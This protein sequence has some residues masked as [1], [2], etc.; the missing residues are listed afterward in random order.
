MGNIFQYQNDLMTWMIWGYPPLLGE[1]PIIYVTS[2]EYSLWRTVAE[3][4]DQYFGRLYLPLTIVIF[5]DYYP[6]CN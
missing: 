2:H 1:T 5:Q 3:I 4:F 6:Y